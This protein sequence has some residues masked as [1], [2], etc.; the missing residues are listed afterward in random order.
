MGE[1]E[2]EIIDLVTQLQL[3]TTILEGAH[4]LG[5]QGRKVDPQDIGLVIKSGQRHIGRLGQLA[6]ID[7]L[8]TAQFL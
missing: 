2:S 6:A 8:G 4:W 7:K 1:A 5:L 3:N